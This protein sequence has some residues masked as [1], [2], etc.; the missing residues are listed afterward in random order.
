MTWEALALSSSAL[1]REAVRVM[2]TREVHRLLVIEGN[3]LVRLLNTMDILRAL[4]PDRPTSP[5]QGF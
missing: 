3:R 2:V 5:D 4:V 1:L